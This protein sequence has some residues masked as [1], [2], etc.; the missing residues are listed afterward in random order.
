MR[1]RRFV[2]LYNDGDQVQVL[3]PVQLLLQQSPGCVQAA[4]VSPQQRGAGEALVQ[5]YLSPQHSSPSVH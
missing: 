3:A 1:A 5:T 4:P 2:A